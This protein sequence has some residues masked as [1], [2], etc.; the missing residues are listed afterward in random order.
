MTWV[1][2]ARFLFVI[3]ADSVKKNFLKIVA[4]QYQYTLLYYSSSTHN[5]FQ[6]YVMLTFDFVD[7]IVVG[8]ACEVAV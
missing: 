5:T 4:E 7:I 6:L 2:I 3:Y 1:N 8:D